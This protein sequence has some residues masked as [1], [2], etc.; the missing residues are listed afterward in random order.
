[1]LGLNDRY[2]VDENGQPADAIWS[3]ADYRSAHSPGPVGCERAPL[4]SERVERR[5]LP[6]DGQGW[7]NSVGPN[8]SAYPQAQ[9]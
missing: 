7:P 8:R 6:D 4:A 9:T 3:V 2:G 5:H 1:M